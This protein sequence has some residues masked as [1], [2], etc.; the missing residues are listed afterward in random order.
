[1]K[2][3]FAPAPPTERA[4][5]AQTLYQSGL[6]L[7]EIGEQMGGITPQRVSQLLGPARHSARQT[8]RAAVASGGIKRP[9]R[10]SRCSTI[11]PV[12]GHHT[13]YAKPLSVE[14]LCQRCH[15]IKHTDPSK[16]MAPPKVHDNPIS[17]AAA[18]L[19]AIGGKAGKGAAKKRSP[20]FY[21]EQGKARAEKRWAKVRAEKAAAENWV[22]RKE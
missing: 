16:P 12:H 2:S 10:C 18:A 17:Q 3:P 4:V 21:R 20:D 11:S 5:Q 1:M 13:N 19:G 14:W 8:L 9:D 22:R 7:R 6:T 15:Q